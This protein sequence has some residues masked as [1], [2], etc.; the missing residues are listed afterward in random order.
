MR[1]LHT[2][3]LHLDSAFSARGA[4]GAQACRG[5]QRELLKRIFDLAKEQ[6]CDMVLIAGD[7]LDTLCASPETRRACVSAF[8]DFGAP[9]VIAP[10]NHDYYTDGGFYAS[11]DMPANVYIFNTPEL[12]YFDFPSLSTTV[13]GYAFTSPSLLTSPLC[14]IGRQREQ[15]A[16]I[17]VLLAHADINSPTSRYAPVTEG[18]LSRH[19][20]DYVA[21]GHVHN[22]SE[23]YLGGKA[24]YCGFPEGR[25]FDE[26][27]EGGVYIVDIGRDR[28]ATVT[29]HNVSKTK[30]MIDEISLD[31]VASEDEIKRLIADKL[32]SM[33]ADAHTHVRIEL[34][35][36]L[37]LDGELDI[38]SLEMS[39][40]GG[41]AYLELIDETLCLPDGDYLER[42]VTIKGE[43]YRALRPMLYTDDVSERA[44]ALRALKIGL[45]AIEGRDFTDRGADNEDN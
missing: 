4:L 8:A 15:S 10:G 6:G 26:L 9:V 1:F 25:A 11:K 14:E 39:C 5:R 24:R 12:Q 18:D 30:Y 36:V 45:S 34:S 31:G 32:A 21:L 29:R 13:A 17:L 7:M 22:S 38:A 28:K 23:E 16:D 20:F 3:D 42:D 33:G 43:L 41:V 2:G 35:G 44:L 19:G 40:G 27:G 37:P